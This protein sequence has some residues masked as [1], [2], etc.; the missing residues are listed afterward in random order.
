MN[1]RSFK[2][3]AVQFGLA[4]TTINR[5]YNEAVSYHKLRKH[6]KSK[7]SDES[8]DSNCSDEEEREASE[9]S[10]ESLEEQPEPQEEQMAGTE[11]DPKIP[12]MLKQEPV[13]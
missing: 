2:D 9:T 5:N 7:K 11:E 12:Q 1:P 13:E 10:G 6:K 3:L 8:A 4:P